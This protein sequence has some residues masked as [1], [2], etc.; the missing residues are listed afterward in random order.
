MAGRAY[1]P[2][3]NTILLGEGARL[4]ALH[5]GGNH[6]NVVD[7]PTPDRNVTSDRLEATPPKYLASSGDM[8]DAHEA[9]VVAFS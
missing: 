7:G 4:P 5:S 1:R 6:R 3:M 8:F 2:V 9:I